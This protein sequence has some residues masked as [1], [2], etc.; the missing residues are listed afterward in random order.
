MGA[1]HGFHVRIEDR[2][3]VGAA[4]GRL[5]RGRSRRPSRS[6]CRD[7]ASG[8]GGVCRRPRA[9]TSEPS[10]AAAV[11]FEEYW[12]HDF[13]AVLLPQATIATR[14]EVERVAGALSAAFPRLRRRV[15]DVVI[16][17][18]FA[19][20]L[21]CE[22]LHEGCW[23]GIV[24]PTGRRVDF[25]ERHEL[26]VS[27]GRIRSDRMMLNHARILTQPV[28]Q[29]PPAGLSCADRYVEPFIS[30]ST[31]RETGDVRSNIAILALSSVRQS[32]VV[33]T[34]HRSRDGRPSRGRWTASARAMTGLG[35]RAGSSALA[36]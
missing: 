14:G 17:D 31:R 36:R 15:V 24:Q 3:T 8:S 5:G 22:G 35:S 29:R 28:R 9:G 25:D 13:G 18:R 16:G 27:D 20:H 34:N 32:I 26:L 21:E 30:A 12:T 10:S 11:P 2:S 19:V 6:R 1:N 7:R 33:L 23:H 4:L